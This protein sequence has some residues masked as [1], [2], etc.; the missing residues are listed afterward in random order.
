MEEMTRVSSGT[1][2]STCAAPFCCYTVDITL[3]T[4]VDLPVSCLPEM[5]TA[6]MGQGWFADWRL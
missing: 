4:G 2:H 3:E 1:E 5:S 6:E